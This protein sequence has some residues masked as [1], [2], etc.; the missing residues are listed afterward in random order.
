[1]KRYG[2]GSIFPEMIE[3]HRGRI[4]RKP[5]SEHSRSRIAFFMILLLSLFGVLGTRIFELTVIKGSYY[6]DLAEGNRIKEVRIQAARG[7]IYDRGGIPLTRNVPEAGV[8]EGIKREY[9]YGAALSHVLGYTGEIDLRELNEKNL[10]EPFDTRY[11]SGDIVGKMGIEKS[12]DKILRGRPGR[13][14]TEVDSQGR[15]VR[16]I[17]EVRPKEGANVT[18]TI[19]LELQKIATSSM[20]GKKGAVVA[21]DPRTGEVLALY[22]SPSFDPNVFVSGIG[23]EDILSDPDKLLFNRAIGGVYPPGSTFKIVTA[24][25]A[26]SAGAISKETF[27]EDTGVIVIGPFRFNNW[28]FTQYGRKEGQVDIIKALRRSNDIFFYKTGEFLGIT[29]LASFAKRVGVGT[30]LWIDIEGEESGLM[31]D[32]EWRWRERGGKWYLGDTYIV[33]IGQG[34]LLTTPLQVN[35]WTNIVANV[36]RLCRPHLVSNLSDLSNLCKDIGIKKETIDLVRNGLIG[37]CQPGGTGWPL[38][39]FKI[40]NSKVKIDGRN[41]LE[42]YEATTS[43]QKMVELVT[44]CKTGTAEFGDPEDKTHAWFTI[45]APAYDPQISITVLVERGG[46]GSSVAAPIAKKMLE[47][48]FGRK[49]K[50]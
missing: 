20:E 45:F 49:I 10:T 36:G 38:F 34:D 26:L 35:A 18:L 42:T 15:Y 50:N 23:V 9:P 14:L 29:K 22:S 47:E 21:T 2:F 3:Q 4:F 28:Y 6:R 8:V 12:Y 37:A 24:V 27:I 5:Q 31:P 33:A 13:K 48:W 39:K 25:A 16:D 11:F 40:Q 1:M 30:K 41:F 19:D 7:I 32:P 44:A 43:A 17:G 46:E